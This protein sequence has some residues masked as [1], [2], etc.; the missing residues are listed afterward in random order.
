MTPCWKPVSLRN[1][2]SEPWHLFLNTARHFANA[3]EVIADPKGAPIIEYRNKPLDKKAAIERLN[4]L[5]NG[6]TPSISVDPRGRYKQIWKSPSLLGHLAMQASQDLLGHRPPIACP[7][8]VTFASNHPDATYCSKL[9]R[10]RY[11]K[12]AQRDRER[13]SSSRAK[14][15]RR[16]RAKDRKPVV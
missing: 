11:H 12:R 3:V 5:A 6:V 7:C 4:Q 1:Q 9:C 13:K 2:Y 14:S 15:R 8:G 10:D 16:G